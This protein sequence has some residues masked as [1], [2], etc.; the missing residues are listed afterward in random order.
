MESLRILVI[1]KELPRFPGKGSAVRLLHLSR[2]L[3]E[4]FRLTLMVLD[5]EPS[6]SVNVPWFE[7]IVFFP[8]N[9]RTDSFIGATLGGLASIGS[10]EKVQY[11]LT[12]R[13]KE[14]QIFTPPY[15]TRME[16][17][18]STIERHAN[19]N[20]HGFLVSTDALA[21]AIRAIPTHGLAV[22]DCHRVS[23]LALRA[24][25][26]SC[27]KRKN[28]RELQ[29]EAKRFRGYEKRFWPK[30]DIIS[31]T[32]SEDMEAVE[33]SG[34]VDPDKLALVPNGVDSDYFAFHAGP[35]NSDMLLFVGDFA[36]PSNVEAAVSIIED[37]LPEIRRRRPSCKMVISGRNAPEHLRRMAAQNGV[38]LRENVS[39]IRK[40]YHEAFAFIAPYHSGGGARLTVLESFASGLPVVTST[41][42]LHGLHA[43]HKKEIMVADSSVDFALA[44]E[45]LE[46]SPQLYESI[47]HNARKYADSTHR[48]D[49]VAGRMAEIFI[50]QH[51]I[52]ARKFGRSS[53]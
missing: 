19:A 46:S 32:S 18:I 43:D 23:S 13:P 2:L 39:D 30:Y 17:E 10:V 21:A 35:R 20:F 34:I 25:A 5:E 49:K 44:I 3:A 47:Q 42:G 50:R 15:L 53:T 22:L 36:T 8:F 12:N 4:D 31:L 48:W 45:E 40:L 11:K 6:I 41:F 51:T 24:E 1:S 7:K 29:I 27:S 38:E 37:I 9:R 14:A 52:N 28:C 26:D 33:R 16:R